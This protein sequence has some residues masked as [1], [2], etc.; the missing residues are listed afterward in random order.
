MPRR[1][2]PPKRIDRPSRL[3]IRALDRN[4]R[5]ITL[6]P[7]DTVRVFPEMGPGGRHPLD[8]DGA[9]F[10]VD[11][12]RATYRTVLDTAPSFDAPACLHL[13]ECVVLTQSSWARCDQLE[14]VK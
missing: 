6:Y 14:A 9:G 11:T 12:V 7:G 5:F 4:G 13:T 10:Y 1:P 3:P 2:R 8:V